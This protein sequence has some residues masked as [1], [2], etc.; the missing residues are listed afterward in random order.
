M[1]LVE[2]FVDGQTG[3]GKTF[4]MGTA[5][6][7]NLNSEQQ[8]IVPRFINDLFARLASKSQQL[9]GFD[10]QVYVTFLELYNEDLVDLLSIEQF[11][12][13]RRRTSSTSAMCDISIREDVHGNIYWSGVREEPCANPDDLLGFLEKG[14]MCR[15][16]GSTDMNAVSS[17]SHAIFSVI[18]K[19]QIP[20]EDQSGHRTVISKFHFTDLAGSERLKRTNAQGERAREGIAIN[21]GLLALGNVISALGDGSRRS[22]HVPYRDSKLTRL[23]QDSLG[24]N[25]QTL[26]MACVSPSDSNFLETLS[27]LKYANRARN[28]KN[29]AVVNQEFA[30]ASEEVNQLRSQISKLKAEIETLRSGNATSESTTGGNHNGEV[31]I[32]REE[33]NQLRNRIRQISDEL[34]QVTSQR[35]T[36]LMERDTSHAGTGDTDKATQHPMITQ[37]HQTIQSLRNQ[38]ADTQERLAA[39]ESSHVTRG[40]QQSSGRASNTQRKPAPQQHSSSQRRRVGRKRRNGST[41]TRTTVAF[42]STRRSKVPNTAHKTTRSSTRVHTSINEEKSDQVAHE[43]IESWLKATI[44]S[45]D[46]SV[47]SDVRS[48]VRNSIEKTRAEIEKGLKVLEDIKPKEN[49]LVTNDQEHAVFECDLLADDELFE[50][51]RSEEN[52][53]IFRELEHELQDNSS[54]AEILELQDSADDSTLSAKTSLDKGRSRMASC[55]TTFSY[56]DYEIADLDDT[57]PQV[58][59]MIDQ[60]QSD[61]RLKEELVAQLEKSETEYSGMRKKFAQKLYSLLDEIH[62]LKNERDQAMQPRPNEQR[63]NQQMIDDV[64]HSYEKKMSKLAVELDTLRRKYT[65]TSSA[66]Q[67]TRCQ[68]ETMLR[69]LRVNLE[70]LKT[71]KKRIIRQMKDEA[72]RIKEKMVGQEREIQRLRRKQARDAESKKQ[73]ERE[74]RQAQAA[75]Q[76]RADEVVVANEKTKQLIQILKKAVQG[77][78]VLN[79]ELL[80]QCA[81]FINLNIS[82]VASARASQR[83]RGKKKS[84]VPVEV[85]ASKKKNLLDRALFQF[86]HGKQA[87]LE[88]KQLISKR[89]ELSQQ[90]SDLLSEREDLLAGED[91]VSEPL[92]CAVKQFMD[93]RLETIEA[94][95]SYLNA[96]IYA[97][98]NDAAHEIMG[99]DGKEVLTLDLA[100][101]TEKRVTFADKVTKDATSADE[102]SDVDHLEGSFLVP[103]NADPDTCYDMAVRLLKS[104][105]ADE[106]ERI[107]ETLID[108]VVALR[109]GEYNRQVSVQQ[110]EKT[111]QDLRRTLIVMKKAAIELT[112]E[113]EKKMRKLGDSKRASSLK[114]GPTKAHVIDD[115]SDDHDSAIDLQIEEHFQQVGTI[116]DKIYNDGIRGAIMSPTWNEYHS[117][118]ELFASESRRKSTVDESEFRTHLRPSPP[119][120]L[121]DK[122]AAS[123]PLKPSISPLV[124]R[125]DSMTSPEQFLHHFMQGSALISN[126]QRQSSQ[127]SAVLMTPADFVKY[128]ADRESS[129]SSHKSCHKR[130]SSIHSDTVSWSSYGSTNPTSGLCSVDYNKPTVDAPVAPVH[131]PNRRRALSFQQPPPRVVRHRL[132]LRELS[133]G[134]GVRDPAE[135]AMPHQPSPLQQGYRVSE[136]PVGFGDGPLTPAFQKLPLYRRPASAFAVPRAA[137]TIA[138]PFHQRPFHIDESPSESYNSNR[139]T[140]TMSSGSVFDRLAAVQTKASRAKRS[141]SSSFRHSSG[142][143]DEIR[144][145]WDL[146]QTIE[147]V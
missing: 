10:Y 37:Y 24:G 144:R 7:G 43:D 46:I 90:K 29:R 39:V 146:E 31:R 82:L 105:A 116:F 75:L 129:T 54:V 27:T 41:T 104:L 30:G 91:H 103:S 127:T 125:R 139:H 23:L 85:R 126:D 124:R 111:V 18:L 141:P 86:I 120:S 8:G 109:M 118:K 25:S 16:T 87:I 143:F 113:N 131:T 65:Q 80:S 61:I 92:D 84:D 110:L 1:P 6:D 98:Q 48:D 99:D 114:G 71:E 2:K 14:S 93:E 38:L 81:K 55:D 33:V 66:I 62:G 26:M 57:N 19:Q 20:E 123:G 89:D 36:L 77:G 112:I 64:K 11:N 88:M 78:G 128:Q 119:P 56:T 96:R 12:R 140:R 147:A 117:R 145:R 21:A 68:S 72:G 142:S 102:W 15:T 122:S 9:S 28:I 17:R 73:L 53:M 35:D 95:I 136:A 133:S 60:I 47:S 115:A 74:H 101:R 63:K 45:I 52:L 107:M 44:G 100:S 79:D 108:D 34:C 3:S 32:L 40:T 5:L 138:T 135:H 137:K 132:S 83:A 13:A 97:L 70:S 121:T 134:A 50:T 22:T 42:R 49:E 58:Y 67:S 59:R 4:S 94:E 76:K 51:L 130:R 69:A 106:S